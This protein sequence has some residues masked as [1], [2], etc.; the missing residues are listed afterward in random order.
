[1]SFQAWDTVCRLMFT[2]WGA[3]RERE[4]G[5]QGYGWS[6]SLRQIVKV[7]VAQR[8]LTLCDPMDCIG[9]QAP[10]SMEFS[11]QEYWSGLPF[12]SPGDHSLLQDQTPV[13]CIAGRFFTVWATR[14]AQTWLSLIKINSL[15]FILFFEGLSWPTAWGIFVSQSGIEPVFP[16]LEG[17]F[18][19][20]GPQLR[21]PQF[22]F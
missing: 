17:R 2:G 9:C 11:R 4:W 1:M 7:L 6:T 3:V 14:E 8:H 15:S 20:T 19:T 22:S 13:A 10:L 12:P 16:A 5:D 18:L 21:V